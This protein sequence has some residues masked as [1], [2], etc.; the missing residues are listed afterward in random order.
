MLKALARKSR[1]VVIRECQICPDH[2]IANWNGIAQL[3]HGSKQVD[4]SVIM[5]K[6]I[7]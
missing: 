5:R 1:G 4:Y 7:L 6:S 3:G 2:R